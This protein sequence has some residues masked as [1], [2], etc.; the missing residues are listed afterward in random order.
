MQTL[1]LIDLCV[2]TTFLIS[3]RRTCQSLVQ[4]W[5]LTVIYYQLNYFNKTQYTFIFNVITII[6]FL[7]AFTFP[8]FDTIIIINNYRLL[9]VMFP[10]FRQMNLQID[11]WAF[12]IIFRKLFHIKFF[13]L[14]SPCVSLWNIWIYLQTSKIP[15]K[16]C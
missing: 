16:I 4:L 7:F 14:K 1:H 2:G 9:L 13:R 5:W 10:L 6:F 12:I 11:I 8:C 3:R 15:W